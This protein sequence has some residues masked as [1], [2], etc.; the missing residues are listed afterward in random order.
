M[1]PAASQAFTRQEIA[2]ANITVNRTGTEGF[3]P[4]PYPETGSGKTVTQGDSV[5]FTSSDSNSI[6]FYAQSGLFYVT[7]CSGKTNN[8]DTKFTA[9]GIGT[10]LGLCVAPSS[11]GGYTLSQSPLPSAMG[12]G[13]TRGNGDT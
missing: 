2:M 1:T 6:D 5:E 7:G 9:P 8:G 11:A 12:A 3:S 4:T 13:T 10:K